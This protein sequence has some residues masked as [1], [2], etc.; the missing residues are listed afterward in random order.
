LF[1]LQLTFQGTIKRGF[2]GGIALDDIRIADGA[3]RHIGSCDFEYDICGLFNP[4]GKDTYDWLRNSGS[5][6]LSLTGPP[7]DHTTNTD[8]GIWE[9]DCFCLC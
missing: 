4:S 8:E 6:A 2:K 9:F 5:A 7:V 1:V 3:C